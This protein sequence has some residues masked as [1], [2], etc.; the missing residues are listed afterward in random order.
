M[1]VAKK[2]AIPPNVLRAVDALLAPY[3][4]AVS[5]LLDGC[6]PR[7][8]R[9]YCNGVTAAKYLGVSVTTLYRYT[10]A[11]L[12][13][14]YTAGGRTSRRYS[15]DELDNIMNNKEMEQ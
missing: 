3:G 9:G 10:A 2:E 15:Y 12:V 5:G 1:K 7:T 11:G 13:H 6:A 8:G 4:V 14:P